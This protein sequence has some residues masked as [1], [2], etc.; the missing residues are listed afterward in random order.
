MVTY[1]SRLLPRDDHRCA[2]AKTLRHY[3]N[4][5]LSAKTPR[6]WPPYASN[7]QVSDLVGFQRDK[8]LRHLAIN[9]VA[10]G[11]EGQVLRYLH[12]FQPT[13]LWL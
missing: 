13:T 4:Q 12:V 8:T 5:A 6:F 3:A 1:K 11:S 2:E 7:Q 9:Q 10:L